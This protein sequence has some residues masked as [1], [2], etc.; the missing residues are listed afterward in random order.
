MEF[1]IRE[2]WFR[3][4]DP[5]ISAISV[6]DMTLFVDLAVTLTFRYAFAWSMGA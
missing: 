2:P 1:C 5:P 6:L 3:P 4:S